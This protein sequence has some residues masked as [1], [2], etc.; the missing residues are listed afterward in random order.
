MHFQVDADLLVPTNR[1]SRSLTTNKSSILKHQFKNYFFIVSK[2][3]YSGEY[4]KIRSN[5]LIENDPHEFA[6]KVWSSIL[7]KGETDEK[8]AIEALEK[9]CNARFIPYYHSY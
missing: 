6:V 7:K 5:M 9:A 8:T 3:L 2:Q 1:L 4:F